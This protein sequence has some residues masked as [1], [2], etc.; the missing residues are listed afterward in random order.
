RPGMHVNSAITFT[1]DRTGDV[2]ADTESAKSFALAFA[3]CPQSISGFTA[4]AD[5]ENKGVAAH[6]CVAMA[7]LAG[8]FH[9]YRNVCQLFD[10]IYPDQDREPCGPECREHP[11]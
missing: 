3:Q 8:V 11:A 5:G 2:V 1:R 7:E 6:W 9:F 10:E 4:L